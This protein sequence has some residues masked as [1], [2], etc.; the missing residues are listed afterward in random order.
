MATK[1]DNNK[2]SKGALAPQMFSVSVLLHK[3]GA[4]WVA[5]CLEYDVAVQG[6]SP[7]EAKNRFLRTLGSQIL[8]DLL[9]GRAPL[10]SLPQAPS[11]YFNNLGGTKACGPELPVYVRVDESKAKPPQLVRVCHAQF[12][13][14]A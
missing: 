7:E 11:Q 8:D 4:A 2:K 10:S 9:D 14:A 3:D 1:K 12:L 13:E 5:Q 6:P